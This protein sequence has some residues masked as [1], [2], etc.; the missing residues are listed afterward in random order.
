MSDTLVKV[1][2]AYSHEDAAYLDDDSLLGYLKELAKESIAFW[3]DRNIHIGES[4]D[5]VIKA[6]IQDAHIALVLVSQGFLDS[7]YCQKEEINRF[8]AQKSNLFPIILSSC[9]WQRHEWLRSRQYLPGGNETIEEHYAAPDRRKELFLDLWRQLRERAELIRK[10]DIVLTPSL[11]YSGKTKIDLL[12]R[13]GPDWRNLADYF[14]IPAYDQAR[15]ERGEEGRRIWV[16]LESRARLHELPEAL[17]VIGRSD[18][19]HG[20]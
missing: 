8:L 3:T 16:W 12:R 4:W 15:F 14:E 17:A 20:R 1:F 13:L 11:T 7:A 2:V 19:L 10:T 5:E 6:N 9:E 18:L